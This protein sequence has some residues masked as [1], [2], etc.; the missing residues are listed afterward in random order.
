[1]F[2][3]GGLV[4]E[5][6]CGGSVLDDAASA[7][8]SPR[9]ENPPPG[10]RLERT[11]VHPDLNADT[12]RDGT[13][14]AVTAGGELPEGRVGRPSNRR[15]GRRSRASWWPRGA[16]PKGRPAFRWGLAP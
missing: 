14:M 5:R 7:A 3:G 11:A 6:A 13:R 1:M 4:C 2:S 12:L 16:G 9:P 8:T 15:H 10:A